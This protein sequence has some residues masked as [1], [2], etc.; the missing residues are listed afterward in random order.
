MAL[1]RWSHWLIVVAACCAG[2]ALPSKASAQNNTL[3]GGS[4]ALSGGVGMGAGSVGGGMGTA[5]G[6]NA[7][8]S[9]AMPSNAM[10]SNALPSNALPG[11]TGTTGLTGMT[12]ATGQR[13][14]LVGQSNTRFIGQTA[15]TQPTTNTQNQRGQNRNTGNRNTQGQ[16]Q[17]QNN[18]QQ[19]R[20]VRPQL[21]V[22]FSAPRPT[23]DVLSSRI[24][25]RFTKVAKQKGYEDVTVVVDGHTVTLRGEVDSAAAKRMASMLVKL[26]PGVRTVQNEITVREAPV[27]ADE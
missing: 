27:P 12:G 25:N 3:F 15:T 4:G 18:Q 1:E 22:A 23:A 11:M 6:S 24:S 14:G 26:E 17:G 19:Q 13:T 8:P 9:N 10:P 16:N 20:S 5:F 2:A 7:M 21:V